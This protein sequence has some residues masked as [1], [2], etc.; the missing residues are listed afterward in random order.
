ML[1]LKDLLNSGISELSPYE[2]GKPIEDLERELGLSD[3]VKIA[4]NENPLGPSPFAVSKIKEYLN[5]LHRYPDGNAYNLKRALSRK[6]SISK[7]RITIGNGSNDIIEFISRCFLSSSDSAIF[8]EYA[9]AVY[10][11]VVQGL[12]AEGIEVPSLDW[13]HDLERILSSI[14]PNTKLIFIANPNNPTGTFIPKDDVLNFAK[15]VP[16]NVL[17]LLDQAY[18]DYSSYEEEDVDFNDIESIPNLLISRTFSKAY[19]LAGLRVGFSYSSSEMSDYLNRIRQPF[20]TNTLALVAAE[21][22]LKDKE[23]LKRSLE[24]NKLEKEKLYQE[25]D[26]LGFEYI[27]SHANFISFDCKDYADTA[28]EAFLKEGIIVRSMRVYKM[29]RHLRVTIGTSEENRKFINALKKI[30]NG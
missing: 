18:F 22:A 10:P 25:F 7:D 13:S 1:R 30:H 3:I 12:G 6:F 4:S 5:D 24:V 21:E 16:E 23:H 2:P 19:G 9:F 28:F 15:Q 26:E 14:K 17:V 11:L 20:N 27:P 8:S 29:P